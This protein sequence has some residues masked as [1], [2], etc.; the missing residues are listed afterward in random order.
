MKRIIACLALLALCVSPLAAVA[1]K[2]P[3]VAAGMPSCKGSDPVVWVNTKSMVYHLQGDSYYGKTKAGKYACQSDAVAM[4]A[5]AS[6][7]KVKGGT[8]PDA[9]A[10]SSPMLHGKR[11]PKPEPTATP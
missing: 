2:T 5:H 1:K 10:T 7:S 8:A 4:G 6:G 11:M 9:M 3:P